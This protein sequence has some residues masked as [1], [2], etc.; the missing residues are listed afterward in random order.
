VHWLLKDASGRLIWQKSRGSLT[1]LRQYIDTRNTY[2]YPPDMLDN[3]LEQA[4]HQRVMLIADK[5]GMGKTTVLTHLSKQ[6]KQKFPTHWVVRIDLNDHTDVLENQAKQKM[7]AVEFLSKQLL[8]LVSPLEKS[9]FKQRFGEGR[10]VLMLDGF[11]EISPNYKETVIDLLQSLK[12]TAIEQLWVTTRPHLREELEDKLQQFSYTLEPFNKGNQVDFLTKYWKKTLESELKSKCEEELLKTYATYATELIGKLAQSISDGEK[13]FT[14][15]PL[16]TRMLAEA[17]DKELKIFRDSDKSKPDLPNTLNLLKLYKRFFNRKY[18]IYQEEK[19]KTPLS[20]EVAKEQ[21]KYY[22]ESIIEKHQILAL[23]VLFTEKQVGIFQVNSKSSFSEEQLTRIGIVQYIDN[24]PQFIHR[25]FAEYYVADFLTNQLTKETQHSS[26]VQEFLLKYIFLKGYYQVIRAFIDGFL[27]KS[28]QP[29]KTLK[30]YGNRINELWKKGSLKNSHTAILHQAAQEDNAHI[31]DFLLNS[32]NKGK[33]TDT[34]SKMFL[35]DKNHSTAWHRAAENG[36]VK[37]LKKL[38]E[39]AK[40]LNIKN[41][42]FLNKYGAGLTAWDLAAERSEVRVLEKLWDW[43]EEI[44]PNPKKLKND[45]LLAT[46]DSEKSAWYWAAENGNIEAIKKLWEWAEEL[47]LK[48]NLL[49]DHEYL[50]ETA[51]LKAAENGNIEILKK[52][53]EYAEELNLKDYLLLCKDYFRSTAWHKAAEE[54][55]IEI[56]KKLWEYAEELNLKNYLLLAKDSSKETAWHKAVRKNNIEALKKLWEW[57]EEVNLKNDLFLA[58]N[59]WKQTVWHKAVANGNVEALKKIWEWAEELNLKNDLFLA[60]NSWKQ[61]AWHCAAMNGNVEALK[62]LWE[63]AKELNLKNDDLLLSKDSLEKT[64]WH[65]A[66]EKGKAEALKTIWEWAE[67]A[68][69]NLK[70]ELLLIKNEVGK[71]A[72]NLASKRSDVSLL[73]KLWCWVEEKQPDTKKLKNELYLSKDNSIK[74]AWEWAVE[75]GNVEA[76]KKLW[77]WAEELNLKNHLFQAGEHII[78]TAWHQAAEKGNIEVLKKLWEYAEEVN[79]KNDLLLAKDYMKRTAWHTAAKYGKAKALKKI[80]EWAEEVKFKENLFLGKDTCEKNAWHFAAMYGDIETLKELWKCAKELNLK[81]ELLLAKDKDRQTA[82]HW[83]AREGRVRVLEKLW[84]W[85]KKQNLNLK[86]DLLLVL[87]E[88][89]LLI[90]ESEKTQVLELLEWYSS[91][92]KADLSAAELNESSTGNLKAAEEYLEDTGQD[93]VAGSSSGCTPRRR[94]RY[95]SG[96]EEGQEQEGHLFPYETLK[97]W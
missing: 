77:E 38:W 23:Q 29:T 10:V 80:W 81:N 68:Q 76:L 85:A 60:K 40:E 75:N 22:L 6:I 47:N 57:A 21:R 72:W 55:N 44:Q 95:L 90:P 97:Q 25:S 31:I 5:A 62:K 36:N 49:L 78:N 13:E 91:E 16:Q 4:Q 32:L 66:A 69:P 1:A 18:D 89:D 52:L 17:F 46:G 92:V 84:G 15:V 11:D 59:S 58:K 37:A 86:N 9:L 93:V 50:D 26:E 45:L 7:E 39:W 61:T 41:D 63:W 88:D 79:L 53:W 30:E 2:S 64:A 83:A 67:E 56:L 19:A 74:T 94:C 34:L 12:K 8:K 42:L 27:K 65:L 54:G 35:E 3:L 73:E 96:C 20:N 70:D 48:N 82:W 43:A 33:H 24:K 51:W 87:L 71:T 28:K 14:G